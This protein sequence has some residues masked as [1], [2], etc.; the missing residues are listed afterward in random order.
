MRLFIKRVF[1]LLLCLLLLIVLLVAALLLYLTLTDYRP[2][3]I[4]PLEIS[5]GAAEAPVTGGTLSILSFNVGYGGLGAAEDFFM[6]GGKGVRP[7]AQGDVEK[8]LGALSVIVADSGADI[9]LLQEVDSG[10]KRSYGIDELPYF[11]M[12]QSS[13]A[14]ALNYSCNYVPFPLP[15]IGKVNSGLLTVS[16]FSIDSAERRS[17]PSPFSWP[18]STANLK[19]C[20]LVSY[21]PVEGTDKQL[22]IVNL[23]LEAYTEGEGRKAQMDLLSGFLQEEYEKGNYVIAGGDFNCVFPG[24]EELFPVINPQLWTPGSIGE[25]DLPEGFKLAFDADTPTCRL[26]NRPYEPKNPETQHYIIDGYIISPNV[27]LVSVE[28]LDCGFEYSD[29]NPVRLEVRLG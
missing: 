22:V 9:I 18:V 23:H 16:G 1:H 7:S 2:A 11:T 27:E 5:D 26:L 8:N 21:L 13:T 29:H 24:S 6:D 19:R 14:Y 10:S 17:L 4:E 20:L 15:T 28:T 3:Q 25:E 12:A